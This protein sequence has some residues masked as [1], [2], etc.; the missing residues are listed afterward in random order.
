VVTSI[1]SYQELFEQLLQED[2]GI[3]QYF[4]YVVT[5]VIKP[6]T[7]LPIGHLCAQSRREAQRG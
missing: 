1:A 5:K 6:M 2:L 3:K 4:T 7:A